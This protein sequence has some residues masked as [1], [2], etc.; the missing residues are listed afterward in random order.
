MGRVIMEAVG[1][2]P[3]PGC[4]PVSTALSPTAAFRV[5]RWI[6]GSSWG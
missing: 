3:L 1:T 4:M 5:T 6:S 2:V